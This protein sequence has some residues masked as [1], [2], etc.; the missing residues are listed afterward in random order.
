MLL[1]SV[2]PRDAH[3]ITILIYIFFIKNGMTV[4]IVSTICLRILTLTYFF[5]K[6]DI[7]NK[8]AITTHVA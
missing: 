6:I 3:P 7:F 1:L 5:N 4:N 2:I 8:L